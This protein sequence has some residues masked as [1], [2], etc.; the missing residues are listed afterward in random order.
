MKWAQAGLPDW[1][2]WDWMSWQ[3][4]DKYGFFSSRVDGET[5]EHILFLN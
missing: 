4:G 5:C 1:V 2:S 3:L